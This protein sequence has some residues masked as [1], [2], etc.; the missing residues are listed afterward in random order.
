MVIVVTVSWHTVSRRNTGIV[1]Y[2]QA[3]V[4]HHSLN[5]TFLANSLALQLTLRTIAH[6]TALR[7]RDTLSI[8]FFIWKVGASFLPTSDTSGEVD[9]THKALTLTTWR[10][11]RRC[12]SLGLKTLTRD[13]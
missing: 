4:S 13:G 3:H 11:K 12:I 9:T 2:V 6:T 8:F 10:Y 5:N 7:Q 1:L